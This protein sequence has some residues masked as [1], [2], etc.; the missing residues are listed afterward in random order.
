M[1]KAPKSNPVGFPKFLKLLSKGIACITFGYL[2]N[3]LPLSIEQAV[4]S[5]EFQSFLV[6]QTLSQDIEEEE[7][8]SIDYDTDKAGDILIT[9]GSA[10]ATG[11]GQD[12]RPGRQTSG[13]TRGYCV[14]DS[15]PVLTSLIPDSNLGITVSPN[16]NLW[17]YVPDTPEEV[18]KGYFVL[19]DEAG[20]DVI[21]EI[22]F[23]FPNQAGYISISLPSDFAL[24]VGSEY[25]WVFELECRP[26]E[27]TIYVEGWIKRIPLEPGLQAQ[28]SVPNSE[29]HNIYTENYIWFDAIDNLAT[30]RL[31]SP[32][33]P[34]L[35]EAW[36]TLLSQGGENLGNLPEQPI[37]GDILALP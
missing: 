28:L 35:I 22:E 30:Q 2:F 13:E 23:D 33:N 4:Y 36:I 25:Q 18:V 5:A 24:E 32:N 19:Q 1:M 34:A 20:N 37:L 11:F 21:D 26:S 12:K 31:A 8:L 29:H 3:L 10:Q 6:S 27:P 17:F 16:P 14:S 9:E 15:S 7:V